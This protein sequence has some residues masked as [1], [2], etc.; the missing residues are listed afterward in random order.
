MSILNS[1][2]EGMHQ[3]H[4][5]T[6]KSSSKIIITELVAKRLKTETGFDFKSTGNSYQKLFGMI[7][8]VIAGNSTAIEYK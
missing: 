7:V 1:I 5:I 6:N 4:K 2:R 8:H 3:Y